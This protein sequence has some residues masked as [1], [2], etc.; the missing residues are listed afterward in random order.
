MYP[1]FFPNSV[2]GGGIVTGVQGGATRMVLL[3]TSVSMGAS[4]GRK[5]LN[6]WKKNGMEESVLDVVFVRRKALTV[7]VVY[8]E[9][10]GSIVNAA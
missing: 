7:F 4:M 1:G 10:E 9:D 2:F 3:L 5:Q 8:V 6:R